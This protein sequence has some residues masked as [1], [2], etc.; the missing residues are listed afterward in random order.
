[1]FGS[2]STSSSY[3]GIM[4]VRRVQLSAKKKAAWIAILSSGIAVAI[5]TFAANKTWELYKHRKLGPK[6]VNAALRLEG[7]KL[8]LFVRNNSDE[9]LD[10]TQAKIEIEDPSLVESTT[11]GAY[12]DISKI[13]GVST[14]SGTAKLELAGNRLIV[15]INITQA[16]APGA[17][18]QFAVTLVDITGPL[19]FS[20]A[21]IHAEVTDIKGHAYTATR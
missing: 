20:K 17:A 7:G 21:T 3:L 6:Y 16:I 14:T 18:D 5:F 19:D 4:L 15:N 1:M 2:L 9:P 10:L 8:L 13:Y 12:P 11:L